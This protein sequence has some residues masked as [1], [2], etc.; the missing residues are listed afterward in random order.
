MKICWD[1]L[2]GLR[3]NRTGSFMK[4]SVTYAERSACN[5]CGDS[6]LTNKHAPSSFC[7][8]SCRQTGENNANYGNTYTIKTRK[9]I[10]FHSKNR[11][12]ST[13]TRKK[14]S[15]QMTGCGNHRWKGGISKIPYC[16]DWTTALKKFIKERDGYRCMNP[17][18]NSKSPNNLCVHHIDYNKKSCEPENLITLCRSCNGSANVDRDWHRA[19]YQA[20]ILQRYKYKY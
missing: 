11:M 16:L 2:E 5:K 3:L 4:K 13:A 14:K 1:M 7:S 9:L 8:R 12:C 10:G 20:I 17:C 15:K 6:Y 19:W 18:C